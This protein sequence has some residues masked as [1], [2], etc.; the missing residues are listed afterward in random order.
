MKPRASRKEKRKEEEK[1]RRNQGM[2]CLEL[3]YG[4]L[5]GFLYGIVRICMDTCLEVWNTSFCVE[6]FFEMVVWFGCGPELRKNLYREKGWVLGEM[7]S[8]FLTHVF[9]LAITWSSLIQ[10][11]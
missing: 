5:Y 6:S 2:E 10:I 8:V 9:V 1:K 4:F 7:L 3:L 11:K